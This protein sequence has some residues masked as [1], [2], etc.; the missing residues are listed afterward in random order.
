MSNR[1]NLVSLAEAADYLRCNERTVRR[2]I[3]TGEL[4]AYRLGRLIRIDLDE[5]DAAMKPIPTTKPGDAA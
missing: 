2:H 4:T 1:R 5:L 3:A